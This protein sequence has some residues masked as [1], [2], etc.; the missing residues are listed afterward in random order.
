[1]LCNHK[2]SQVWLILWLKSKENIEKRFVQSFLTYYFLYKRI[3]QSWVKGNYNGNIQ[4]W[5]PFFKQIIQSALFLSRKIELNFLQ[6]LKPKT[7]KNT[8]PNARYWF[9]PPFSL[10]QNCVKGNYT[11][12]T[13]K[14]RKKMQNEVNHCCFLLD[15]YENRLLHLLKP[16]DLPS[17]PSK[18]VFSSKIENA[19]SGLLAN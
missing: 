16:S 1:M 5:H 13:K 4:K 3:V 11:Y 19:K 2:R 15:N 18:Y 10:V 14:N 7:A 9:F 12:A 6:I 8:F 17:E